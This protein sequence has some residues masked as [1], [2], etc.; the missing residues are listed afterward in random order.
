MYEK[1]CRLCPRQC[2]VNRE[3][4]ERGYCKQGRLRVAKAMLHHWEEPVISGTGGSG[5]V[6]F[7]G[8]TL[9]CIFCQ[10]ETISHDGQGH[11]VAPAQLRQIFE[12]LIAQGAENIDLITATHFLPE[13]LPALQPKLP[14]PVCYNCGGYESVQTLQ[15]L[16]GVVDV[17][18]P[19]LKYA[20]ADLAARLSGARDYFPAAT[21]AIQEMA[22][23][24]G[25]PV[26]E[27]GLLKKGVLIRHLILPG[28]VENSLRVLD[29]IGETF[30]P[31]E[32][33]VSLMRQY[34]PTDRVRNLPPFDRM[35]TGEEYEAALSWMYLNDLQGFTQ[36]AAAAG[37]DCVPDF[38]DWAPPEEES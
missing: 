12:N 33:L 5:A 28:Q 21:A 14:V 2:G 20:D 9:G 11:C 27:N 7:A 10:N 17:Y 32:V 22:R 13:I 3:A 18:L 26:V 35:V 6:F 30:A 24:V 16:E 29:W 25:A 15:K 38:S 31:G 19:D 4:G 1:S 8:C 37:T 34:T 36:E 23:Q